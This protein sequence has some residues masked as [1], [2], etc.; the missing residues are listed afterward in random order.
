LGGAPGRASAGWAV[1]GLGPGGWRGVSSVGVG[2]DATESGG[3][4]AGRA[5]WDWMGDTGPG[6]T[7]TGRMATVRCGWDQRRRWHIETTFRMRLRFSAVRFTGEREGVG[8]G[9]KSSQTSVT[10]RYIRQLIDE[11]TA[12]CIRQLTNECIWL[13]SSIWAIFLGAGTE[14]YSPVV[15]RNI[16]SLRNVPYFP[17]VHLNWL[18]RQ[19]HP[20]LE[21]AS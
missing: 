8:T 12:R 4:G 13:S 11:Y 15:P 6:G 17:I 5:T 3:A 16:K 20:F 9:T 2:V 7:A 21:L 19:E 14:E 18:C 1:P 10:A